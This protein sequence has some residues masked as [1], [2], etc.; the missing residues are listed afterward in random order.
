VIEYRVIVGDDARRMTELLN[1][2][3]TAGFAL[4]DAVMPAGRGELI[5]TM[6]RDDGEVVMTP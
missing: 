1:A 5:A 4:I 6:W 3:A 2:G